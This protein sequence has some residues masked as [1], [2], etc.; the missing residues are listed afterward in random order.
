[1]AFLL[2]LQAVQDGELC[3]W[4]VEVYVLTT[5]KPVQG[6]TSR[7]LTPDLWPLMG[8]LPPHFQQILKPQEDGLVEGWPWRMAQACIGLSGF[9]FQ[10]RSTLL[11]V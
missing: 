9:K 1:M 10:V 8:S 5:V 3:T 4:E 2:Q 6:R 7:P 11:S